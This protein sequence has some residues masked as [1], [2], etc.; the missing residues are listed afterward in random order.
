MLTFLEKLWNDKKMCIY[1]RVPHQN[2]YSLRFGYSADE[3]GTVVMI[4]VFAYFCMELV[5]S[6][7]DFR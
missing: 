4:Y 5:A 6:Q 1:D 3:G 7:V 2:D